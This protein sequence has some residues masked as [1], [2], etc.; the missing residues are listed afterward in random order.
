MSQ[1]FV[2]MQNSCLILLVC[3]IVDDF[4]ITGTDYS[5]KWF[6]QNIRQRFTI[7]TETHFPQPL[8]FNG[9]IIRQAADYLTLLLISEFTA[10]IKLLHIPREHRKQ[11]DAPSTPAKV[12]SIQSLAGQMNLLGR[13]PAPHYVFAAS[14][15]H[16][17]L[18]ISMS[19]ISRSCSR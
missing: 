11:A 12:K 1:Y 16:Q 6:N 18:V 15:L 17:T 7:G 10:E 2:M 9:C 4:L 19:D 14:Y 13:T 3:K 5:I 8:H